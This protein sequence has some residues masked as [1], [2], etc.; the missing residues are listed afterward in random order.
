MLG[1]ATRGGLMTAIEISALGI[2]Y[3]VHRG[4]LLRFRFRFGIGKV[5][6]I[7]NLVI[8]ALLCLSGLWVAQRMVVT[9][10][11]GGASASPLDM[12]I[13]AVVN[14]INL[15]LNLFGWVVM[16]GLPRVATTHRST[17]PKDERAA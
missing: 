2:L 16:S 12:A 10:L 1:E 5:E 8:G 13:A 11:A 7:V 3:A 17:S 9:L 15:L 6:Q 14:A 4:Q